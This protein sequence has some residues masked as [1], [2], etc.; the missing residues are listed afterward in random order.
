MAPY[1]GQNQIHDPPLL[2]GQ[3]LLPLLCPIIHIRPVS[4][5]DATRVEIVIQTLSTEYSALA[6]LSHPSSCVQIHTLA[7]HL[8][9]IHACLRLL[10]ELV[11]RYSATKLWALSSTVPMNLL[12]LTLPECLLDMSTGHV[13]NTYTTE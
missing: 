1:Q 9:S 4:L 5:Y 7:R 11:W 8:D 3:V 13:H 6:L 12:S 10:P 2:L